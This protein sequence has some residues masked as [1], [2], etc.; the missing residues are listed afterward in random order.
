M[1]APAPTALRAR[2][3]PLTLAVARSAFRRQSPF[4]LDGQDDLRMECELAEA[5]GQQCSTSAGAG[6]EA[7]DSSSSADSLPSPSPPRHS[8][9]PRERERR[10]LRRRLSGG[11]GSSGGSIVAQV[12]HS[13][14]SNVLMK[15]ETSEVL[16]GLGELRVAGSRA[17]NRPTARAGAVRLNPDL[18]P[19][20]DPN[21][22]PNPDPDP[23]PDPSPPRRPERYAARARSDPDPRLRAHPHPN[24]HTRP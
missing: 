23:N 3:R 18:N 20:P 1:R 16:A 4:A 15:M 17:S 22:N 12:V 8:S 5:M 10:G 9:P 14:F 7:D 13:I 6:T 24:L 11:G 19:N 21:L 2:V